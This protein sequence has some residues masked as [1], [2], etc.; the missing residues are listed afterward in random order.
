MDF[1]DLIALRTRLFG[2]CSAPFELV[3]RVVE[4]EVDGK[5]DVPR[6]RLQ[7]TESAR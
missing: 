5:E 4:A 7:R 6:G 3:D 2:L 1:F